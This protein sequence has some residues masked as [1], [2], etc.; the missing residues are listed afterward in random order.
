[1]HVIA[2][3]YPGYGVYNYSKESATETKIMNDAEEVY[4]F[5]V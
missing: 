2:V 1:M 4:K 5:I 3:E